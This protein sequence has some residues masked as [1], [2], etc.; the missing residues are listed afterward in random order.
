MDS[1]FSKYD[2]DRIFGS[3]HNCFRHKLVGAIELNPEYEPEDMD[4]AVRWALASA[5]QEYTPFLAIMVPPKWNG[6]AYQQYQGSKNYHHLVTIPRDQFKFKSATHWQEI[7]EYRGHPKWDVNLV[8]IANSAGMQRYY[9]H[10]RIQKHTNAAA[11]KLGIKIPNLKSINVF[12]N[13]DNGYGY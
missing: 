8:I 2:R 6:T 7:Q 3:R 1:Y 13:A 5:D 11:L 10:N 12:D 4:K 9:N